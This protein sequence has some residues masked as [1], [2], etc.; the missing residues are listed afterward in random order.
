[1]LLAY[2]GRLELPRRAVS[3]PGLRSS[4][5]DGRLPARSGHPGKRSA[6]HAGQGDPVYG[7]TAQ[8]KTSTCSR[9]VPLRPGAG[10]SHPSCSIPTMIAGASWVW[11]LGFHAVVAALL[12]V[13]S[14]MPGHRHQTRYP[15][16][17]AWLGTAGLV[18]AA[19]A[20]AAW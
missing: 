4:A 16:F 7:R 20:F 15:Q 11:W 18:L 17:F 1:S 14:L 12:L 3:R 13:D 19:A 8:C 9:I 2:Q 10:Q 5:S 6:G